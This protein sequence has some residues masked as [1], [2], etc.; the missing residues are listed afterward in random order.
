MKKLL[1]LLCLFVQVGLAS[2][3]RID[4]LKRELGRLDS[5]PNGYTKDTLTFNTIKAVMRAYADRNVDSAFYYNKLITKLCIEK[6]LENHLVYAYFYTGLLYQIKGDNYKALKF[7]YKALSM[8]QKLNQYVQMAASY[9]QLAQ[10]Y[11]SLHNNEKAMRLCQQGLAILDKTSFTESYRERLALLNAQG[12]IYREQGE[13]ENSLKVSQSMYDLSRIKP[14]NPWYESHGLH[15][16]GLVYKELS[17]LT[18]AIDYHKKALVIA[19]KNGSI[20][21]AVNILVNT[22]DIY[23]RQKNWQQAIAYCNQAKELA[24]SAKNTRIVAEAY[25]KLYKIYQ[26]I[27]NPASA[28]KAYENYVL[29]KDSLSKETNQQRLEMLQAQYQ[30]TNAL[31]KEQLQ[32]QQLAQTRNGLF[33]G[34]VAILLIAGLLFWNNRQLQT[35][36]REID[37]QRTLLEMVREQ[38][39]ENNKTLE[40]RVNERTEELVRANQ[41]LIRKNEAIKAAHF[42]GQTV[43]RKRVALELH[44]NLSSLLSAVNMSIQVINPQNL[45]EPEQTVYRNVKQLIQKAYAEVRNISHNILPIELERDGLVTTLNT[46]IN[47]L[48]QNSPLELSLAITGFQK[49]VPVEI[50]FNVYSIVFELVNNAIKHANATTI[51]VSLHRTDS[52]IDLRVTDDGIGL[53]QNTGKRGIGLQNIQTRL[54][55]L[56]GTFDS[57]QPTDKGTRIH[58]KIPIETVHINGNE[59]NT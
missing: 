7:L 29:L 30:N 46:L 27:G 38:L 45:S 21:L 4:S 35:K 3:P 15:A 11:L 16:I 58:I 52:G 20:E 51:L 55:S 43:E 41:E 37:K 5:Q 36:N 28:L 19:R 25:E 33:G 56:G 50:E 9:G 14:Y 53:E 59:W 49:R 48:N 22:A 6:K 18:K 47:Q 26:Q 40:I 13:L 10:A 54:D 8:A 24:Q 57:K 1:P 17:D 23:I 44:D 42:K 31:Q 34:I 32:S 12:V 39:A 2:T